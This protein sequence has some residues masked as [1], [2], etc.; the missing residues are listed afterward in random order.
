MRDAEGYDL[1]KAEMGIST[2]GETKYTSLADAGGYFLPEYKL[3]VDE[4]EREYRK[5]FL[6]PPR[7][8]GQL[9][10]YDDGEGDDGEVWWLEI[11]GK[12]GKDVP[13]RPFE[14]SPNLF[15]HFAEIQTPEEALAFVNRNGLPTRNSQQ[16][17]NIQDSAQR[18][19]DLLVKGSQRIGNREPL[20]PPGPARSLGDVNV[21]VLIKQADPREAPTLIFRPKTLLDGLRLQ[22][23]YAFTE[24][25]PPRACRQCGRLIENPRKNATYCSPKCKETWFSLERTRRKHRANPAATPAARPARR[26]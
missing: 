13:F 17:R 4:A 8:K 21:A 16:F 7:V 26:R 18:V 3:L 10:A 24:E 12:S 2:G 6:R 11:H 22:L 25:R 23:A 5:K 15:R 1:V 19:H 14:G 9:L 20:V